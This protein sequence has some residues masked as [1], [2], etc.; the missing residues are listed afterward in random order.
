VPPREGWGEWRWLCVCVGGGVFLSIHG[1]L[2]IE[3]QA[4]AVTQRSGGGRGAPV[5]I[6]LAG[7]GVLVLKGCKARLLMS[8][9]RVDGG[10][11]TPTPPAFCCGW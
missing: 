11:L 4:A 3:V 5:G 2:R 10:E 1:V 6:V 7:F 9:R 8:V